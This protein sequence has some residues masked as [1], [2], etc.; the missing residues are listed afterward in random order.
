M[1]IAADAADLVAIDADRARALI[2][3]SRA[4]H[5]VAT[6]GGAVELRRAG[7]RPAGRMRIA[8]IGSL[9]RQVLRAMAILAEA[10]AVAA[11]ARR[12]VLLRLDGV[13]ADVIAA[14]DEVG[15]DALGPLDFDPGGH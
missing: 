2:V 7:E 15:V 5:D 6:R 14:V 1:R 12:R 4:R 11:T 8:G 3:A 10:R 13:A 9:W